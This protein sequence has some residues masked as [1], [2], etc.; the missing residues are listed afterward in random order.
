MNKLTIHE[1]SEKLRK[2]EIS[3]IELA[4][5]CFA[6]IEAIDRDVFGKLD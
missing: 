3:A 1:L 2:K 6:R 5:S 4:E